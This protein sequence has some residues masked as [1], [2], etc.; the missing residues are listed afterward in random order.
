MLLVIGVFLLGLV[1]D[2]I[3]SYWNLAVTAKKPLASSLWAT[4]THISSILFTLMVIE[5]NYPLL[6][7]YLVGCFIGCYWSIWRLK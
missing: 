6:L 5:D 2:L 1:T 4:S 7:V 3:W